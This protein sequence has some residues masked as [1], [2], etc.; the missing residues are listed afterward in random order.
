MLREIS[1]QQFFD[2][3]HY[4]QLEPF[5]EKRS[6]YRSAQIAQALYNINRDTKKHKQPFPLED[7]VIPFGDTEE[8][9]SKKRQTWE[10]QLLIAQAL[11]AMYQPLLEQENKKKS[12]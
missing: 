12:N 5:G 2:W 4:Y 3:L 11:T 7:F 6:D 8:K 10:D 1:A 9:K